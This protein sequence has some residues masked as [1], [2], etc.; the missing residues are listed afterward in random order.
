MLTY[1]EMYMSLPGIELL[2]PEAGLALIGRLRELAVDKPY[3]RS[4]THGPDDL[5]GPLHPT[6]ETLLSGDPRAIAIRLFFCGAPAD[7]AEATELLGSCLFDQLRKAGIL[8]TSS[9]VVGP[10]PSSARGPLVALIAGAPRLYEAINGGLWRF[11]LQL[12]LVRGLYL[13]SDYLGE[14]ADAVM[15]AGETTG[16]LYQAALPS[17]PVGRVLDLG[18]GAGTLALLLAKHAGEVVATDINPRAVALAKFN[19]A[20]N[21]IPNVE[22]HV[23]DLFDAVIGERFDLIVSQ[24]PYYPFGVGA[25]PGQTHT[26]LHGGVRGDEL[27][28]RIVEAIPQ[29]L[30]PSGRAVVFTS[31]IDSSH[32]PIPP[33]HRVLE[34]STTRLELHGARQSLRI[35]EHT[36]DPKPGWLALVA[37]PAEC[38]GDVHSW[39][40]DQIMAAENLARAPDPELLAASLRMPVG[41]VRFEEGARLFLRCPPESLAPFTPIDEET[42]ELLANIGAGAPVG[43]LERVRD[44]LRRRLLII[45]P[46][47]V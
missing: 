36:G 39:R 33:E 46:C 43:R 23:S 25:P 29:F 34:L 40:I 19:A 12:R 47:L 21:G 6:R 31:W 5:R 41:A 8:V 38:W 45:N 3:I 20:V 15:G 4:M 10:M 1:H 14:E 9:P 26:F 24:P 13:F 44:A 37:V 11:P 32:L 17:R 42:W 18:C 30:R 27:A 16:V 28:T 22:F 2:T 35:I 7:E